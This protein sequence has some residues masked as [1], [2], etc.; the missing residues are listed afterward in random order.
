MLTEWDRW[1]PGSE[2]IAHELKW[3]VPERWV[4]F[5]SLPGS[6]RYPEDEDEYAMVLER[7]NTILG[8]L[9]RPGTEVVLLTTGY[10]ETPLPIR[11]YDELLSLDP[12]A[13]PWR[14]VAMHER[15]S[16]WSDTTY[17]HI[18]A[19]RSDWQ[20]GRFDPLVRLIADDVIA[21]VMI[22]A[23]DC[24]WLLHPYD[25][26]MDLIVESSAER[27]RLKDKYSGWLSNSPGGL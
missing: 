4:R 8:E 20:P 7:H 27:D 2:P 18:D 17:W 12:E 23:P 5:H 16:N 9:T 25:G 11:S 6:K 19:S 15:D 22:V 26:G 10:S 3:A 14:T 24:R 1:F 13:S 21:N